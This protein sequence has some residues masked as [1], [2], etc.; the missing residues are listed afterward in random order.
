MPFPFDGFAG[1]TGIDELRRKTRGIPESDVLTKQRRDLLDQHDSKLPDT[2]AVTAAWDS[3][4]DMTLLSETDVVRLI[5]TP[6]YVIDEFLR[7]QSVENLE[8][9]NIS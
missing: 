3:Y 2:K 9:L 1:L 6:Q 5:H 7:F 8:A 4:N